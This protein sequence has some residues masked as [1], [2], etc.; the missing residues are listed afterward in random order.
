MSFD[1]WTGN[2][3]QTYHSVGSF[4]ARDKGKE[5]LVPLENDDDEFTSVHLLVV[6]NVKI[7][8]Q[9][10]NTITQN[11]Q[12][13][14]GPQDSKEFRE[15]LKQKLKST[16]DLIKETQKLI[17]RLSMLAGST[18]DNRN[19]KM[20]KQKVDLW[21]DEFENFL[22]NFKKL[23]DIANQKM[24][25]VPLSY[26]INMG[27][28]STN[29]F[30]DGDQEEY[31]RKQVQ[32]QK[33]ARLDAEREYQDILIHERDKEIKAIQNQMGEVNEIFKHLA[34][35]VDEQ[36]EIVDNIQSNITSAGSHVEIATSEVKE[37]ERLQEGT[38]NK[39]CWLAVCCAVTIII[40]VVVVIIVVKV[41][42]K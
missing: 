14:G 17:Q 21:N 8:R 9:N 3:P 27:R 19:R 29:P 36:G 10:F 28:T 33:F 38:R 4:G 6:E 12:A 20:K 31:E 37:A 1:D 32:Q 30:D 13:V 25:D 40:L 24:E 16:Q 11:A 2:T 18:G 5:T 34:S 42:Q 7:L 26:R 22:E 15:I 39:L 23:T 35:L 41:K